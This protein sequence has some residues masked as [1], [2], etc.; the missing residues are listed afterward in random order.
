MHAFRSFSCQS[1]TSSCGIVTEI[2]FMTHPVYFRVPQIKINEKK[3]DGSRKIINSPNK[4]AA[5]QG[6]SKLASFL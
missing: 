1:R 3:F 4:I 5:L 6:D 2:M